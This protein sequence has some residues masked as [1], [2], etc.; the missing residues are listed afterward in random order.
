MTIEVGILI[1]AFGL[2]ISYQVYQL[3]RTKSV[4]DDGQER[5]ELKVELGYIRRGVDNILLDLKAKEIQLND[6]SERITRVE[7]SAKQAH[8]RLDTIENKGDA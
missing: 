4:K 3:N 8:R 6:H 7:E 1:A 5:A 2:V